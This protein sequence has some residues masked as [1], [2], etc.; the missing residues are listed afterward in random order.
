[1]APFDGL[2]RWGVALCLAAAL[3]ACSSG[4]GGRSGPASREAGRIAADLGTP[5][6]VVR[7]GPIANDAY[8]A[9]LDARKRGDCAAAIERLTPVANL[10]PGYEGAQS[11]LGDC[12]V[13]TAPTATATVFA[14]GLTWLIRAADAGWAEAQGR[15]AELYA[16]GPADMRKPAEA[17]YWLALYRFNAQKAR[18]GFEPVAAETEAK[19]AAALTPQII[20]SGEAR[21]ATWRRK[22]WI[23][24]K[25]AEE[26]PMPGPGGGPPR[27][28][29]RRSPGADAPG[30]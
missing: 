4:G 12:L 6:Q 30:P 22:A 27:R 16:L 8:V 24:P 21:A 3:A 11:A 29:P 10:G 28:G 15:L 26:P 17:A 13:R 20:A 5:G 9:G 1:M 14:D 25:T 2:L 18:I 19:I 7:P 23:P